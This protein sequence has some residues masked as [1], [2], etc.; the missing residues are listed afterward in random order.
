M[1]AVLTLGAC[2]SDGTVES[3]EAA[4]PAQVVTTTTSTTTTTT[5]IATTTTEPPPTIEECLAEVPLQV[6]LGQLLFPVMTQNEFGEATVLAA[7][8]QIAGVVVLGAPDSRI[9][10]DIE[11]MQTTSLVGPSIIAVDEEGGRVQRLDGLVGEVPSARSMSAMTIDEVRELSRAHAEAI[12]ALGFTMNLA[13]VLDL[14]NGTYI[15]D[16]SF[17]ADPSTVADYGFAFADGILD[18][19]L[20]PTAKHFPGH[21]PGTDS[22]TGL[23]T[24]PALDQLRTADLVPFVAA[25]ERGDLPI[26]VGHLV[27]PDLTD[28]EPATLSPAAVTGLLR[29]ELG[30]D[31]LVMTDALNMDAISVQRS[32]DEAAEL[33]IIAGVDL[34]MLGRMADVVPT[35][36][37]LTEAVGSGRLTMERVDESFLRVLDTKGIAVCDLPADVAPAIACEGVTSGACAIANG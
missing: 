15:R 29:N 13:P 4:A 25:I 19:G 26:M 2:T 20:V 21:G 5:T 9:E 27:V 28:G 18:A 30:F 1:A 23:P 37:R 10:R 35:I 8:G 33:S 11:A 22:H 17:S 36:E 12:G 7:A 34:A 32:N 14:D 31:G 3:T 6:K 16:R 24:L